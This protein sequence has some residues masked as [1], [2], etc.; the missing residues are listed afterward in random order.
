MYAQ[1]AQGQAE[2]AR[3]GAREAEEQLSAQQRR[4]EEAARQLAEAERHQA[5]AAQ[6]LEMREGTLQ[7]LTLENQRLQVKFLNYPFIR[8]LH[9]S[10]NIFSWS[11]RRVLTK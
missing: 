10:E 11:K 9:I 5:E 1:A 8:K 6:K 7:E 2:Q 3:A 4:A